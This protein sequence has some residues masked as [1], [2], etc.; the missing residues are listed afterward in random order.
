MSQFLLLKITILNFLILV[1]LVIFLIV[2]VFSLFSFFF[3]NMS[4]KKTPMLYFIDYLYDVNKLYYLYPFFR[5]YY[6]FFIF[7]NNKKML[8]ITLF[9]GFLFIM[10]SMF[11]YSILLNYMKN[12]NHLTKLGN[13]YDI[14]PTQDSSYFYILMIILS[15]NILFRFLL[16]W[17]RI[18]MNNIILFRQN[19]TLAIIKDFDLLLNKYDWLKPFIQPVFNKTFIK[20]NITINHL[21]KNETNWLKGGVY[22]AGIAAAAG[23]YS[24]SKTGQ[25]ALIAEEQLLISKQQ[26]YESRKS[27]DFNEMKEG[28]ISQEEYLSRSR[29]R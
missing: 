12:V 17:S 4:L 11:K 14:F 5:I 16:N 2:P 20:N 27:N 10:S 23:V 9:S 13:I 29:N 18:F 21:P 1:L 26:L 19:Y 22:C 25:Q 24:A 7:L 6:Y 3:N 8:L 15:L 28:M